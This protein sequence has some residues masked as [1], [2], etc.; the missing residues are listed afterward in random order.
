MLQA[1][2]ITDD[3]KDAFIELI[4]A[5]HRANTAAKEVGTTGSK[6]RSFRNPKSVHYDEWFAHQ[7]E[8]A[9]RSEEHRRNFEEGLR[10]QIAERAQTSDA[11]LKMQALAYLPEYEN[12]KHTNFRTE[13]NVNVLGRYLPHAPPELLDQMIEAEEKARDLERG[14]IR[15]LPPAEEEA[16]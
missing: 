3:H 14:E 10:D 11:I 12:Q 9:E 7:W 15:L 5:G 8:E 6:M 16:G 2:E 4:Y 1:T 13:V